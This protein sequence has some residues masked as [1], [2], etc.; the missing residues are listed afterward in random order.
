M[1]DADLFIYFF[2]DIFE[3]RTLYRVLREVSIEVR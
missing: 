1:M 3:A 2:R